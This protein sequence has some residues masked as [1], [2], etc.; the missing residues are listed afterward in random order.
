GVAI[1]A[2]DHE[3]R[4]SMVTI[5]MA[6]LLFYNYYCDLYLQGDALTGLLNRRHLE[7]MH[8]KKGRD[9]LLVFLDV[10]DFKLINDRYGHD[11]GDEVLTKLGQLILRHFSRYGLCYRYGG[12]EFVLV[13]KTDEAFFKRLA[14]NFDSALNECREE[15]KRFPFVSYGYET[16]IGGSDFLLAQRKADEN[17]YSYKSEHKR[18]RKNS[19]GFQA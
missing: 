10:D 16:Y 19:D 2:I 17:M 1:Q 4:V 12:D 9:Y 11:Y 15:D 7:N 5:A 8:L 13:L 3:A 18:R 6:F 14:S